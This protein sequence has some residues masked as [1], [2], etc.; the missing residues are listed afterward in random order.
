MTV[1]GDFS[2]K[3][4]GRWAGVLYQQGRV[5]LDADA[6]AQTLLTVDWQD[7]AAR[8][9][10]GSRVAAVPS[11][12]PL[13]FRVER[14]D[15]TTGEVVVTYQPGRV[16]ADGL[17]VRQEGN[18][19]IN[20]VATYLQPPVQDPPGTVGG[21]VAGTRDAVVLEVWREAISDFQ[22]PLELIEPAL[23][24][25][26]TTERLNTAYALRLFR[27]AAGDTCETIDLG[28]HP[29]RKGRL[30]VTFDPTQVVAADCPV[31]ESGGYSGFEHNLYRI[32]IAETGG[33]NVRFKWSQFNGGLTGRVEFD[34]VALRGE[35]KANLAAITSSG[36]DQFYLEALQFDQNLG[37]WAVV[38]GAN[39]TLDA[40]N[41]FV[42]P[43]V[44]GEVVGAIP[45]P[46][47]G[48]EGVFVRLW[49]GLERVIDFP[50]GPNPVTLQDGIHLE[51]DPPGPG[52]A[53][54]PG[55]YWTFPVRAAEIANLGP[56][57]TNQPPEGITYHRV[58]LA[59]LE[60]DGA[61]VLTIDAGTIEDCREVVRPLTELSTC[62][63]FQ[64][65][66]GISSHG[67]FDSIQEAVD[68]LP[69]DGGEVCVL[70]GVYTENVV[71]RNRRGVIISG[72]DGRALVISNAQAPVFHI[73]NSQQI[74]IRGISIYAHDAAPGILAEDTLAVILGRGQDIG[75]TGALHDLTFEGLFVRAVERSAIEVHGAL[76]ITIQ[77]CGI[78]MMDRRSLWPGIFLQAEDALIER[79]TVRVRER[80]IVTLDALIDFF[81]RGAL[82]ANLGA[83]RKLWHLLGI[84]SEGDPIEASA[85]LGGIQ[86]AGLSERVR[87]I[88]NV[89]QGGIGNGITLGSI[90]VVRQDDDDVDI[91]IRVGWVINIDDPCDPCRPGDTSVP[92]PVGDPDGGGELLVP[93]GPLRDIV[94]ERNRI[95]DMG[96]NGIGVA[97]FFNILYQ[98]LV[99]QARRRIIS[100]E[101]LRI[102]GNRIMRCL[103]REL[104]P[105][106]ESMLLFMG[107]GAIA[108]ADVE[109]LLVRDNILEDNGPSYLDPVCGVFVL[110]G[111]GVE[112]DHNRI[113]NNGAFGLGVP[114]DARPGYRGG[115][116]V[117]LCQAPVADSVAI[118]DRVLMEGTPALRVHDNVVSVP[119]GP[120][121]TTRV[122]GSVSVQGNSFTTMGVFPR[123]DI[124]SQ[125]MFGATVTIFNLGRS[126]EDRE[127]I[128]KY[129]DI[130]TDKFR[131]IGI[132]RRGEFTE[133]AETVSVNPGFRAT[134]LLARTRA[135]GLVQVSDNQI[136]FTPMLREREPVAVSSERFRPEINVAR[137]REP[138]S[139]Y[140]SSEFSGTSEAAAGINQPNLLP[141][142][143]GLRLSSI[144]IFSRDDI[145]FHD[146]Q[147][148]VQLADGTLLTQLLAFGDSVRVIGNRFKEGVDDAIFSAITIGGLNATVHN[149]A[150][151]CLLIWPNQPPAAIAEPNIVIASAINPRLC[152]L[153]QNILAKYLTDFIRL[154]G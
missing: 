93:A 9:I 56:F 152:E 77:H 27:M 114:S 90:R 136:I 63:T 76:D 69:A 40:Q 67:D 130:P 34:A 135:S 112:V 110:M 95:L 50:A 119:M 64:V 124:M 78:E 32:E 4:G 26:D 132:N 125:T 71:I 144:A 1:H 86:I 105:I 117:A 80:D 146:N 11:S 147:C 92:D 6:T 48:E 44:G 118:Y 154:R 83:G 38:Y 58:P 126:S 145:G 113:V 25:P 133:N 150:T 103:R 107:Y 123:P 151:H 61:N 23:G 137:L 17:L 12:V 22:M 16:W 53:Y 120:C 66:D 24:G 143:L 81:R 94:I 62:C 109:R 91:G 28:D 127:E 87:I 45:A 42:L 21:T 73:D 140:F 96:L 43:V 55:D 51:F 15:K 33:G 29:E 57:P 116:V 74:T 36:L 115:I 46:V 88:E 13:S 35:V 99:E 108:L 129:D 111:E 5:F 47:P 139:L 7:T 128:Y 82:I 14:A 121:L 8:D 10:I 72:C 153:L 149:Q 20:R 70:P 98:G 106:G 100:V 49:N 131:R 18:A 138:S 37:R 68:R 3:S 41:Q 141:L 85:A 79:N 19:A 89:V 39:V 75:P 65:G 102:E 148:L 54:V 97:G 59:V 52:R 101:R 84:L 134:G 30:T 60:W 31:V 122:L 104:A 142:Q 2:R